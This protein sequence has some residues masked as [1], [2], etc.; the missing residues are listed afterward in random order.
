VIERDKLVDHVATLGTWALPQLQAMQK[1][2]GGALTNARGRGLFM[3]IDLADPA[4]R[5]EL[6][7]RTFANGMLILPSGSQS[8]RFRPSLNTT[9]EDLQR[10]FVI[11]LRSLRE[12][13]SSRPVAAA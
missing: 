12:V 4:A 6:L 1:E 2:S 10:G 9:K 3:A 5:P 11:L 8:I 13:S 7:K